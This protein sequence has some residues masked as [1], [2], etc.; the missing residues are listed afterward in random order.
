MQNIKLLIAE[1]N[2]NNQS[3]NINTD[4]QEASFSEDEIFDVTEESF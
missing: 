3:E 2:E 1:E 4:N